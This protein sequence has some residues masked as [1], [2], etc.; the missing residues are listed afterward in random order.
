MPK[1]KR[2]LSSAT[3]GNPSKQR[4]KLSNQEDVMM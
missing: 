1:G 2:A 3:D 4:P